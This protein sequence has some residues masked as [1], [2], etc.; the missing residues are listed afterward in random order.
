[1]R[2]NWLMKLEIK[3]VFSLQIVCLLKKKSLETMI[4]LIKADLKDQPVK[5]QQCQQ[6][7][8]KWQDLF[9]SNSL[10]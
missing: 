1:M 10:L 9:V 2:L 4:H 3:R 6:C 5:E 8:T 7:Q